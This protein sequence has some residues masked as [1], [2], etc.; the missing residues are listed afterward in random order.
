M[1]KNILSYPQRI[2]RSSELVDVESRDGSALEVYSEKRDPFLEVAQVHRAMKAK[3]FN[4][5]ICMV[6]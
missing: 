1:K 2:L 3:C 5:C 4:N 6:Y